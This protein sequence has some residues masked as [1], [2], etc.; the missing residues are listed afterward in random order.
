MKKIILGLVSL[1][2]LTTSCSKH[3]FDGQSPYSQANK[4]LTFAED[5]NSE[6]NVTAE[7][8]ANHNWGM[9]V[10]PMLDKTPIATTRA[11][12]PNGNEWAADGYTVPSDITDAER[13][14]VLEVFNKKGK[15]SYQSLVNW[16]CFFVQQV[17]KGDSH[18]T[19]GNGGDVVGSNHMDYLY[20][21][22]N[23]H[24]EVVSWWPYE[25]KVVIGENYEDHIFDFNNSNSSDYGGRM[26]MVNSNTNVFGYHNSEDSQSH[27]YFR[28][29]KINGN[30]YVGFDFSGE[31]S[32]PNQQ[33]QRDY[34]YNDWIVKI[35]PGRGTIT[36]PQIEVDY[37]RVMCE[38]LGV[39]HSDF[40]YND[41]VFD[42]K[43][44][45]VGG[46]ITADIILQAAG[47]T[48]PLTIGDHEVH[49]EFGGYPT[50]VM[51][52]TN[53]NIGDHVDGVPPAHFTVTLEG[54]Y[55]T[56]YD[57]INALPVMV[58]LSGGQVVHLTTNPGRPAEMF[59]VPVGTAWANERVSIRDQ[60]PLFVD[61]ITDPNVIWCE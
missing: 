16:D 46:K 54:N 47:G 50:N 43:F 35:V 5:F 7:S 26:L 53:A 41:I 18:Y 48:L 31:G 6:F 59:A 58:R 37:V 45:K 14:A 40:D 60:Y 21:I 9:N 44:T 24:I 56:A 28:M 3:D 42:I 8:Y 27:P 49:N 34:I 55:D 4:E 19:A 15:E 20:T 12:Y 33:I 1:L 10:I 39:S 38:D 30:Y 32:N 57:A 51:I 23:K 36:P 29:E 25:E 61:W 52:N 11:S 13:E 17:Y 2:A 22:T